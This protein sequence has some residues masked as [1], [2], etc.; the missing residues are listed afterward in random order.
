M[1]KLM[2]IKK[3]MGKILREKNV[4]SSVFHSA[5][6]FLPVGTALST[7]CV[8]RRTV[9]R[10][11]L[12]RASDQMCKAEWHRCWHASSPKMLITTR[13]AN[14]R[15]AMAPSRSRV[16]VSEEKRKGS[17]SDH[18]QPL[19]PVVRYLLSGTQDLL[20]E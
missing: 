13:M 18:C 7:H 1:N 6:S 9:L 12:R 16:V 17:L 11:W 14:R 10:T 4:W 20:V 3:K 8:P 2:N 15:T 5:K 19:A